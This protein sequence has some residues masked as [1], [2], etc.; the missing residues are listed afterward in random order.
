[1]KFKEMMTQLKIDLEPMTF[2]EKAEHIWTNFK[3]YIIVFTLLAV[4]IIGYAAT[5][6]TA[7]DQILAGY[8]INV[9]L[10]EK[11]NTLICEELLADLGNP[12]KDQITVVYREYEEDASGLMLESNSMVMTQIAAMVDAEGLDFVLTDKVGMEICLALGIYIDLSE[13]L[14]DAEL[15]AMEGK[16]VYGV[17]EDSDVSIPLA[18]DITD[19]AFAKENVKAKDKVFIGFIGNT[20]HIEN[21]RSLWELI[22]NYETNPGG[23]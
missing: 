14:T 13:I 19:T 4:A 23:Q 5:L 17:P 12:K 1:M 22:K 3:E 16:V 7:K 21:C 20:T 10:N 8:T 15:A 9:E 18:L 2:G 6:L 11:G